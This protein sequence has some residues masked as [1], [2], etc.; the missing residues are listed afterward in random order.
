[1]ELVGEAVAAEPVVVFNP[2]DGDQLYVFAPL[3]VREVEL[4]MQIAVA[5][6]LELSVGLALTVMDLVILSVPDA[7][8]TLSFTV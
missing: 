7:L 2:V 3:T 4:F 8:D 1:M 5:V 6:T